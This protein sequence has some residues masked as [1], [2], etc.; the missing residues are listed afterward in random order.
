MS[1]IGIVQS[2][3][4][5]WIGYFHLINYVD[6]FIVFDE[7]QFTKR[8][9]RN[10]NKIKS[11]NGSFWLT[12]P[13]KTKGK[14]KQKISEV[15]IDGFGWQEKHKK[16]IINVYGSSKYFEEI[17]DLYRP[18]FEEQKFNYLSDL[19]YQIIKLTI[20]YLGLQTKI[21]KSNQF[22]I[23]LGKNH[24]IINLCKQAKSSIYVSGE[25]AKTY[26][27]K[28][29]FDKNGIKIEF[30]KYKNYNLNQNKISYFE[31]L[32][33]LDTLFKYGKNVKELII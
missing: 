9:W 8:Y 27:N 23:V 30:F 6:K 16:S 29:E 10:R 22:N 2:N 21:Y 3:Y 14:Y 19:N 25:V 4:F 20:R 24:R 13:V 26:L 12:V 5:P 18:I 17:Y 15:I 11:K 32:S 1:K 31:N 28:E 7:V 33:I